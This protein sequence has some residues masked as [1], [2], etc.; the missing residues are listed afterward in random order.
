M[1]SEWLQKN[2]IMIPVKELIE[3]LNSPDIVALVVGGV[4]ISF[5]GLLA[6][7]RLKERTPK[8]IAW[9]T[10]VAGLIVFLA[11]LLSGYENQQTSKLLQ[12]KT[13]EI[14]KL[15][16]ENAELAKTNANLNKKIAD[17]LTGGD[18]Y[19]YVVME[20]DKSS[21]WAHLYL[22]HIG[23]YPIRQIEIQLVDQNKLKNNY[24]ER[25]YKLPIA[26]GGDKKDYGN[27]RREVDLTN[28]LNELQQKATKVYKLPI[29]T[30][31]VSY[32]L[33]SFKLPSDKFEYNYRI[34]IFSINGIYDQELKYRKIDG[35]WRFS[36]R[37]KKGYT[38]LEESLHPAIP[39]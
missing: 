4:L 1:L 27:T 19:C 39:L 13:E 5:F 21:G 29:L 35:N 38:I 11:G 20:V 25:L 24:Q 17:F 6:G 32:E 34:R 22:K 37:V 14:A 16:K 2:N 31:S 7:L 30:P 3:Y 15:S 9:G 23:D 8:W 10:F 33:D 12:S 18:S 36:L 28:M 26:I